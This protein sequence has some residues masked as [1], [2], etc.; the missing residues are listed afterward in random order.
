MLCRHI[1]F[2]PSYIPEKPGK[3]EKL[4]YP[5]CGLPMMQRRQ[6]QG[7]CR[8]LYFFPSDT[9]EKVR[10]YGFPPI[11]YPYE[12]KAYVALLPPPHDGEDEKA[13]IM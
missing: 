12:G 3:L 1:D 6:R 2:F 9:P 7:L 11:L 4:M 10:P 5:Y 13:G 8:H